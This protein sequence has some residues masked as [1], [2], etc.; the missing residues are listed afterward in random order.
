MLLEWGLTR[1]NPV[2]APVRPRVVDHAF[3]DTQQIIRVVEGYQRPSTAGSLPGAHRR[4]IASTAATRK[5]S[6]RSL[7][8]ARKCV[9][10][11]FR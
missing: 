10:E 9:V 2:Q 8:M 3:F 7:L 11:Y 1:Q 5:P 4:L 6:C